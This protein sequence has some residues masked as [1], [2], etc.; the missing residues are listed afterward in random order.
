MV[1]RNAW[2]SKA[3]LLAATR[4]PMA[5]RCV[6]DVGP[7]RGW[8]AT[9]LVLGELSGWRTGDIG[10]SLLPDDFSTVILVAFIGQRKSANHSLPCALLDRSNSRKARIGAWTVSEFKTPCRLG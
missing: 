3:R 9:F 7:I 5:L 1:A 4:G 2:G 8:Q 6:W 10:T